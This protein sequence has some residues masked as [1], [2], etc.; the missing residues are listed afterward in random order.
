MSNVPFV[1]L[2]NGVQMPQ[3]GLGVYK[4]PAENAYE[5]VKTALEIGYRHIDTASFYE[6]ERGVGQAIRESGIPREQIFVTTKVWNDQQGYDRTLQAFEQS[7]LELGL[8][9]VDLYLIHWPMPDTYIETWKALEKI[10][11]EGKARAIGVSNFL[12]HHLEH[13]LQEATVLPTVNQIELHPKLFEKET[14]EFCREKEIAV[15]SWS[16]LGRAHYLDDPV[17]TEIA[18]KYEKST[19]QIT[20]RWH[21]QHGLIPI[22]KSIRKERQ[23]E[24]FSVFDFTLSALD[25]N[26]IDEMHENYRTGTHPDEIH[27]RTF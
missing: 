15:S 4:V 27:K 24:N 9:Y 7:L 20:L 3:L 1:R 12:K 2:N 5:N 11:E 8:D 17:L 13:L 16:P 23:I 14:I 21:L 10:Y 19:A 25:M 18:N 6:N 22:P 26:R